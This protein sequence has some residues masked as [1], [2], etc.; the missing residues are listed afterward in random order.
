MNHKWQKRLPEMSRFLMLA[1]MAPG[2]SIDPL[3]LSRRQVQALLAATGRELTW[4]LPVMNREA[5]RWSRLAAQI[6]AETIR[7]DAL[8]ALNSKRGHVAGAGAFS[9]IPD[10]RNPEL[11]RASLI[12]QIMFDFLDTAH[13]RHPTIINGT[14]LHLAIVDALNP[15]GSLGDYYA[16]HPAK[17]DAGYLRALVETC[18]RHCE[19]L[20]SFPLVQS[21]LVQEADKAR[22]ILAVNHLS[23]PTARDSGLRDL[24]EAEFSNKA[25]WSWFEWTAAASGQLQIFILLALAAKPELDER[26]VT[27][28]Y[29]AYWP[30]MP[31]IAT[32]LDSYVDRAEDIDNGYHQYVSHY[33]DP[34]QA[35]ERLSE[36]IEKAAEEMVRLP[37]G[38]HHA[39]ILSC[40]VGLYLTKDSART[41]AMAPGV[42]RMVGAGGS[43]SRALLPVLRI[44]RGA[45][46]QRAA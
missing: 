34:D 15:G 16:H 6:P 43:L 10:Y 30:L 18:R 20:P 7:L 26:E 9:I 23:D 2:R 44:W 42:E 22:R 28:T 45:Y 33:G 5:R 41:P 46:A 32:M 31:L 35:V 12:H 19:A 25:E 3:P 21:L 11:L 40:M 29:D 39:V 1:A 17:D 27:A 36:L 38:H 13:E 37:R 24:A 4:S 8:A 14:T